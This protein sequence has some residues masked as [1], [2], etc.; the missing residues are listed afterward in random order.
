VDI[1]LRFLANELSFEVTDNG[2]GFN[3]A[4]DARGAGLRNM[5]DRVEGMGGRLAIRSEVNRGATISGTVPV[6]AKEAVS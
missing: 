4:K 2:A 6:G 3:P 5:I 1:N